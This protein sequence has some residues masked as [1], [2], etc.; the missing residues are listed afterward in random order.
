MSDVRGR[1]YW[2][3]VFPDP[4]K[5]GRIVRRG[6]LRHEVQW[7]DS[8]GTSLVAIGAL[9]LVSKMGKC[10]EYCKSLLGAARG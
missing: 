3:G 7:D 9:M 2:H 8:E 4:T 10:C 5:T 6:S 1:V